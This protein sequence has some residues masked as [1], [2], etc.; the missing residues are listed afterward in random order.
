MVNAEEGTR[1]GEVSRIGVRKMSYRSLALAMV[2][3][4][5]SADAD[6]EYILRAILGLG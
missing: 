1:Q 5:G 6:Q 4:N 2:E 3:R